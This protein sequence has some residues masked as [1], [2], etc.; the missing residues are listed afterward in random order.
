MQEVFNHLQA[1][2]IK[3]YPEKYKSLKSSVEYL[4]HRIDKDRLHPV[5]SKIK[6]ITHVPEPANVNELR[7]FIGY[8][9]LFQVFNEYVHLVITIVQVVR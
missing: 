7:P 9:I 4:C 2:G 1:A 3:L 5:E 6:A 8:S